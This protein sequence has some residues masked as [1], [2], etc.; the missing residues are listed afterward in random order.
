MVVRSGLQGVKGT[1]DF[2]GRV[3]FQKFVNRLRKAEYDAQRDEIRQDNMDAFLQAMD[4]REKRM[5]AR[6]HW[7][8]LG[9]AMASRRHSFDRI[10]KRDPERRNGIDVEPLYHLIWQRGAAHVLDLV[11]LSGLPTHQVHVRLRRLLA[12]GRIER[13]D[14]GL[15]RV[16]EH[17]E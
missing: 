4:S 1:G 15:Y 14:R 5:N 11:K 16:A 7:L 17:G 10:P 9:K 12:S 8:S 3:S 13:V 2:R 6:A